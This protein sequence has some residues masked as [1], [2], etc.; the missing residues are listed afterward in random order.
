MVAIGE[1]TGLKEKQAGS[2]KAGKQIP[3]DIKQRILLAI[4]DI[5]YGSVEI[6]IHGGK[7]VQIECREKTRIS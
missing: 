7:V 4:A 6:I 3:M 5:E 2:E 1:I